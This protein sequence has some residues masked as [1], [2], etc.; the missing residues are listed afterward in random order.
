MRHHFPSKV[1][2]RGLC[3]EL[4]EDDGLD[5]HLWSRRIGRGGQARRDGSAAPL[6]GR[7][8]DR[9]ACQLCR[10]V[11]VTLDEVLPDC[12]DGV[13]QGLRVVEVAPFPD[14]SR[15]LVTVAS[16]DGK[17]ERE[18]GPET[19]LEHLRHASGHLRCEVA[20]AVTRKRAPLL[21]Y[22][23]AGPPLVAAEHGTGT[24]ERPQAV[25]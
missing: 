7:P 13:L 23:L 5:P 10:Q 14:A 4:G 22:H 18:Y 12:G 1:R 24:R 25:D 8:V 19:V 3:A 20:A 17:A 9:K 16:V 21:V 2:M 11:A 15:L 6:H